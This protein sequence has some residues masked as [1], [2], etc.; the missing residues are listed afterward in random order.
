MAGTASQSSNWG[1]AFRDFI[2]IDFTI[3]SR[4]YHLIITVGKVNF[5]TQ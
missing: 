2:V 5:V 1:T 3:K 4:L